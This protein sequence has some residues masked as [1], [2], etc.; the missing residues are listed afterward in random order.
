MSLFSL[1]WRHSTGIILLLDSNEVKTSEHQIQY[2]IQ[3]P[4]AKSETEDSFVGC[5]NSSNYLKVAE[6][7]RQAAGS[8]AG[9]KQEQSRRMEMTG[10]A[11]VCPWMEEVSWANT[12]DNGADNF[13]SLMSGQ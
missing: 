12:E 3:E 2:Q 6:R 5:Y 1:T 11:E 10:L 7:L 8:G 4:K 13:T 9:W